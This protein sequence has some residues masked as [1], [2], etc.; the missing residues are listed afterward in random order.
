MEKRR[1]V[2]TGVG[3]VNPTG[4]NVTESWKNIQNG[5][6]GIAPITAFDTESFSIKLAA[7]VK[8]FDP[9]HVIDRREQ[10]HLARYSQFALVAAYEA[11]MQ[12]GILGENFDKEH[13][14]AE[15]KADFERIGVIISSGIGE[16]YFF[17][18]SKI[19]AIVA[20][21]CMISSWPI[22]FS[23]NLNL[24]SVCFILFSFSKEL[25]SLQ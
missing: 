7:E 9:S 6:C 18:H 3:T 5:V 16:L 17:S 23:K 1:V 15:Q 8:N 24:S 21:F 10:K 25:R 20:G 22:F 14:S 13:M 12:S 19:S 11:I 2:V 4:N